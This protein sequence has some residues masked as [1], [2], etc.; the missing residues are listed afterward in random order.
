MASV[1]SKWDEWD[2]ENAKKDTHLTV[3][4]KI[5]KNKTGIIICLF[6]VASPT[7]SSRP[8][9]SRYHRNQD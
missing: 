8:D 4:V 1:V 2:F 7:L 6:R 5:W 9:Q 3:S